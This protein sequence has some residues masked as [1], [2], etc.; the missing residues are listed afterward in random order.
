[1]NPLDLIVSKH[2]DWDL[3]LSNE[4]IDCNCNSLST[5]ITCVTFS[6]STINYSSIQWSGAILNINEIYHFGLNGYDNRRVNTIYDNLSINLDKRFILK[7]VSGDTF[8]YNIQTSGNTATLCGGFFQGFYKLDSEDYEVLPEWY[9]DGWTA[10][11]TILKQSGCTICSSGITLNDLYPN[12]SGIF[13]YVGTRAENKFC[14]IIPSLLTYEFESGTTIGSTYLT[15]DYHL[16]PSEGVNPFLYFN[17]NYYSDFCAQLSSTTI[18]LPNCCDGLENNALA[19]RVN[20]NGGI[21][22]RYLTTTGTCINQR[23]QKS[24]AIIEKYSK[25]D[26]IVDNQWY[27]VFIRYSPYNKHNCRT[28]E[29]SYGKLEIFVNGYLKLVEYDM[30]NLA[31]YGYDLPIWQKRGVNYNISIGGGTQGLLEIDEE[32]QIPINICQYS[33]KLTPETVMKGI[34]IDGV[35]YLTETL[36]YKDIL[37]VKDLF[38]QFSAQTI[39]PIVS[40]ACA[41]STTFEITFLNTEFTKI[42]IEQNETFTDCCVPYIND[43]S[44]FVPTIIKCWKFDNDNDWCTILEENFAGTFIGKIQN[45][46]LYDKP[47]NLNEIRCKQ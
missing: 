46:C 40:Y 2:F 9:G 41:E 33:F 18:S 38:T 45:F 30:P 5:P 10:E 4:G 22:F 24:F 39:T 11:F 42:I 3:N 32:P 27:R 16:Y 35:E 1:M 15:N 13:Y 8:C 7:A 21:G 44:Y 14:K 23:F 47:L 36:T 6:S 37:K 19:F 31:P 28:K 43:L 17:P 29:L 25:D 12:N 26:I 34:E 20:E